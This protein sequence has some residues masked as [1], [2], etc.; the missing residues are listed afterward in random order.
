[1]PR[2]ILASTSPY[3]KA[4]LEQLKF[5]FDAFAPNVDEDAFKSQNQSPRE[6]AQRLAIDKAQAVARKHP[7]AV[8]IGGDQLVSFEGEILGKPQTEESAIEQLAKLAGHPH[9]LITAVAV[10]H[11]G[12]CETH[13]DETRLWMRPLDREAIERYVL[14]D[15]PLD[16]AGSYKIESLGITL[17]ERIET[18]DHT[19]ITGLPLLAI[20]R[21]LNVAGIPVP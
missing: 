14:A 21:L 16:C 11:Q 20:T 17:F 7:E 10:C 9:D 3:R 2:L 6:L 19:A 4:Q 1:M 15:R 8:V 5:P 18:Q 12:A 13:L